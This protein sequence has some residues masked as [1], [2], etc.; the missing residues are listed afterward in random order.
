MVGAESVAS[1]LLEYG[2]ERL[3]ND[4]GDTPED[5][6]AINQHVHTLLFHSW[7]TVFHL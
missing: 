4:R 3:T 6:A 1:L 7:V 2:A 5:L